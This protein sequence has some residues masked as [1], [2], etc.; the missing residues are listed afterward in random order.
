MS[1]PV[2]AT[3]ESVTKREDGSL[4]CEAKT[5]DGSVIRWNISGKVMRAALAKEKPPVDQDSNEFKL[6]EFNILF[7]TNMGDGDVSGMRRWFLELLEFV[8]ENL[9]GGFDADKYNA[10]A[11]EIRSW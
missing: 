1:E 3:M 11:E 2:S 5:L 8:K 7:C 9:E 10:A 4:D 6:A